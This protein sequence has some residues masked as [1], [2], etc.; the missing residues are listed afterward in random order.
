[1]VPSRK[2]A[3]A[4]SLAAFSTAG[5]ALGRAQRVVGQEQAREA[6]AVGRLEGQ[7]LAATGS[8]A[9]PRPRRCA[10][11][12][13][14][15]RRSAPS[16]PACPAG[17]APRLSRQTTIEWMML[18]G[19]ITTLMRSGGR[20]NSQCASMTSS[21]LFIIVAES[22]EILRPITQFGWA[23]ASSGVTLCK[24]G[25]V[26]GAERAARGG[27]HD[28][29]DAL[30]PRRCGP[31][32]GTG[33]SPSARCRSAAAR[34]AL[35]HRVHEQPAADHQ[36]LLVGQQQPLAG[37][38]RRQ[39]GGEPGGTDDGGHHAVDLGVGGQVA[40]RLRGRPAPR[41]A[42]RQPAS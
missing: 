2:A 37:A 27:E 17:P 33:R 7:R 23:Q 34:P 21:A 4:S 26:A 31:P 40:Q 1:M 11:G 38:R 28:V 42:H 18:C 20:S 35:A 3:T 8:P 5:A 16:C 12:R 25:R 30:A 6:H 14:G 15:R 39:A 19:W 41:C 29:V 24:R 9:T 10:P 22:T 36:G 32:A 13:T